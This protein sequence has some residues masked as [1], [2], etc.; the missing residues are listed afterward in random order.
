[1]IVLRLLALAAAFSIATLAGC[2][3]SG[4]LKYTVHGEVTHKGK[5]VPKGFIQFLP[6]PGKGNSGPGGGAEII[7]GRY[8]TPAGKGV[9]GGAY[10]IHIT[11]TDGVPYSEGG[12]EIPDG[13]D[14]FPKYE[15]EFD[16]PKESIEKNFNIE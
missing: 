13:K 5:P 8:Q 11:G 14:L 12:E 9:Q 3:T 6:N 7:N 16:F 4:P 2:G 15:V 10:Y 1:M